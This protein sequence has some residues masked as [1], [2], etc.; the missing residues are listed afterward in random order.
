MLMIFASVGGQQ[1][2]IMFS[3]LAT[4]DETILPTWLCDSQWR[5][6]LVQ[7]LVLS[8]SNERVCLYGI[9]LQESINDLRYLNGRP[10]HGTEA[11]HMANA[12]PASGR[13]T[14]ARHAWSLTYYDNNCDC[15]Q[16]EEEV[17]K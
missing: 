5:S 11:S 1:P 3:D 13:S 10:N 12:D 14:E 2:M 16:Q 8:V 6:Q 15:A 4:G 7:I 17:S 9:G